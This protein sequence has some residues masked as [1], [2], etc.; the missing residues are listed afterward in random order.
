[1]DLRLPQQ[2]GNLTIYV[3][4]RITCRKKNRNESRVNYIFIEIRIIKIGTHCGKMIDVFSCL[5]T[6]LSNFFC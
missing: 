3:V 5:F 4:M 6:Y 1:M 2:D